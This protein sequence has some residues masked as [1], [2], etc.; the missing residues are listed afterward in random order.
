MTAST[1]G[2]ESNAKKLARVIFWDWLRRTLHAAGVDPSTT[3]TAVLCGPHGFDARTAQTQGFRHIWCIDADRSYI[4]QARAE[5][6]EWGNHPHNVRWVAGDFFE[7]IKE[8][9]FDVVFFD[10]CGQLLRYAESAAESL[11]TIAAGQR[12]LSLTIGGCYGRDGGSG[13]ATQRCRTASSQLVNVAANKGLGI[14]PGGAFSYSSRR[15]RDDGSVN[16]GSPMMYLSAS[17]CDAERGDDRQSRRAIKRIARRHA[18][19][20]GLDVHALGSDLNGD[21]LRAA[22]VENRD[23]IGGGAKGLAEMFCLD[24]RQV[25]AWLAIDTMKKKRPA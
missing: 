20:R 11:V 6:A 21:A 1:Y 9:Q 7:I 17:L 18:K 19:K 24:W 8:T 25:A 14:R 13:G 23:A 3:S 16:P 15:H 2:G 12:H 4:E 22:V 5:S 10:G